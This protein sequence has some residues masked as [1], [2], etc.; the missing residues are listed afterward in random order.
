MA[1]SWLLASWFSEIWERRAVISCLI[2][3]ESACCSGYCTY[4]MLDVSYL[5]STIVV[6]LSLPF[7]FLICYNFLLGYLSLS[8]CIAPFASLVPFR[9]P[10][11][12]LLVLLD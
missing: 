6:L 3:T 5:G 11:A 9:Q 2:V 8:S 4:L 7:T 12:F 1:N 10:Y